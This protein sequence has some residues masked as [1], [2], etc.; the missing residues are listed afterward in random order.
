MKISTAMA[1]VPN[2]ARMALI[3]FLAWSFI[4]SLAV[5]AIAEFKPP[6]PLPST[7]PADSFSAERALKYVSAISEVAHPLGSNANAAVRDYLV[8]EMSALGLNPQVLT[9]T[10]THVSS[11]QLVIANTKNIVGRLAGSSNSRAL[12]LVAHYDSVPGAPGAADDAAGVATILESI[13][14][15]R[16]GPSL[17][18]DIIVLFTDGEENG[19][20]GADA[21]A[22]SHPWMKEAGLILNF[23]ARGDRGPSLL[24]ETSANNG[25]L[26]EAVARSTRHPVGSSLFYALYKLLPNDTDFSVFRKHDV[27]GLN[28]AFG[29]RLEAYHSRLDTAGNL[30]KASLQHHGSYA[31]DLAR[32]FGGIDLARL[33][34]YGR[35]DVFFDWL[36]SNFVAY[37][38][39]WVVPEQILL[40][41]MLGVTVFLNLRYPN[42]KAHRLLLALLPGIML[43]IAVP[44]VMALVTWLL[45]RI[46]PA[47][48]T[49]GD[50]SANA[51]L[52]VG[53]VFLGACIGGSIFSY[54]RKRFSLQELS[55]AGLVFVCLLNWLITL[56][57]PGGSYMLFWPLLF[58]TLGLLVAQITHKAANDNGQTLASMAGAG[59]AVLLFAPVVYLLYIFLTLQVI[60]VAAIGFLLAVFFLIAIPFNHAAIPQEGR[61]TVLL[62]LLLSAAIMVSIGV[63]LSHYGPNFPRQDNILYSM[64]ADNHH[65]VWISG[66]PSVDTW[67]EQFFSHIPPQRQPMPDYLNGRQQPVLSASAPLFDLDSPT[68]EIKT[69]KREGGLRTIRLNVQSQRNA[70]ALFVTFPPDVKPISVKFGYREIVVNP[71]PG[72][73]AIVLAGMPPQGAEFELIL[74]TQSGISFWLMDKSFGL[75]P[76]VRP[77]SDDLMAADGSDVTL[78]CRKYSL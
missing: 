31:L 22:N 54:S 57:L 51:C 71:G 28:F 76:G 27:P 73:F 5:V 46:L 66:D 47:R 4:V 49:T 48:I 29:E 2:S 33:K 38:E 24:F 9:E 53:L 44:V 56:F 19:L 59:L 43:L 17:K 70:N 62:G 32:Y 55:L 15:L 65:A 58:V 69:D 26:I 45:S 75:P 68:A 77:R 16:T 67:T 35:D 6:I 39:S 8:A 60:T 7:A 78:V 72:P 36:G 21:F 14:A 64:N 10:G 13:R 40:T 3:S 42:L 30:S 41:I 52:L 1:A 34:G 25:A 74:N 50:S 11:R 12:M 63:K 61:R 37:A 20:L 18:N 23:E